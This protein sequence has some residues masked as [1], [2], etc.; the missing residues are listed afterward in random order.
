MAVNA[1]ALHDQDGDTPD[2]VEIN[3][4]SPTPVNLGGWFLTDTA[5][6]LT[7]WRFPS[8]NLPPGGYLVVFASG[9]NRTVAGAELHTNF[10]L[11]AAG[12][13]LALVDPATN[14]ASEF[15]P[16]S[17]PQ[18]AN[19]SFGV[20]QPASAVPLL[21]VGARV[22]VRVPTNGGLGTNWIGREFD[23]GG[24]TMGVNGV[25]YERSPTDPVNYSGLI[26]TDVGSQSYQI[27]GTFYARFPFPLS[28]PAAYSDYRLLLRYDDGFVVWLNGEEVARRNAPDNLAWNS[29]ATGQHVDDQA[30]VAEEFNLAEFE[31]LLVAGTNVLAIQ[32]LN[33]SVTSSDFLILPTVQAVPVTNR[34]VS[35]R[36]FT[37][38]TPGRPNVGGV[39]ELGPIIRNVSHSPPSPLDEQDLLVTAQVTPAFSPISL[40]TLHYRVMFG[41]EVAVPMLDDGAHGDGAAGDRAYGATIPAAASTPGQMVRY[42]I[43]AIDT[44]N[45]PSRIPLLL[46]P[47]GSAEYLGTTVQAPAVTS[48]LPILQWF[49]VDR[50]AAETLTGTRCSLF[51][52]GELYDNIFVRIRGGTALGW[53]KKNYKFEMNED[54]PFLLHPDLP[55][56]NEFNLNATYTDKSYVRSVLTTELSLAAGLPSPEI[57]HLH[58]RQNNQFY[59]VALFVEQVDTDFLRRHGLDENGVLYKVGPGS[60]YDSTGSFEK[61][62][63]RTES[64]ADLQALIDSLGLSRPALDARVFDSFDLPSLVNYVATI[65]VSQNID[66]TD[67]N[68][69]LYRDTLGS[70]E[71]RLFPWDLDL[72][73]GPDYLNTDT[74]V[75]TLCDTAAPHCPSHPFIGTRPYLLHA[76]KWNRLHEAVVK[77]PR[78]REM[79]LRRIRTLTDR[80][81]ATP[82]FQNRIEE[83]YPQLAADVQLDR[84]RWGA[85]AHFPGQTYTL[86]QALD[87]IKKEYL[88]PRLPFLT[89]ATIVGIG[90]NMPRSQPTNVVITITSW[91]NTPVSGNQDEEYVRL[92]NPNGFAVDISGWK[93]DGGIEHTFKPGT[94]I[95]A[96]DAIYLSPNVV[97]F[98]SRAAAPRGGQA[99][100]VQGNYS[101][102]LSAWGETLTLTDDQGRF[103]SS[104]SLVGTPS[105]AQQYLRIT[106]IMYNPVP[107]PGNTNDAQQYEYIELKNTSP[108]LPLDLSG[109]RLTNGVQFSF[110]GSAV[111]SLAPGQIV[112][113]VR[114]QEAFMARYGGAGVP[115]AGIAGQY[116]GA[117]DNAG[118]T[119]RLEDG[120]GEKILEFAYNN[121]WYPITDGLGF[122]LVVRDESAPWDSW[123]EKE[124]WRA[125]GYLNG[126]PGGADPAPRNIAPVRVNEVLAGTD[127]SAMDAIEL[128]NPTV[129]AVDL[130]GWFLTD[131][132]YAPKKYR[133]PGAVTILPNGYLVFDA[134]QLG[135]ESGGFTFSEH[136]NGVYLFSGD[137]NTNLTGYSHG[138]DFAASPGAAAFGRYVT[139]QGEEHFVLQSLATLGATNALPQ[140]G[141]VVIA[142]IMYHPPDLTN[143]A[144]DTLGEF[145]ELQNITATNVPLYRLSGDKPG[146]GSLVRTNTWRLRNAVD[147]D[148]PNDVIL[149]ANSRLLVV[150]FAPTN[151][152]NLA[153][154][155]ARYG[156][157]DG[158]PILGP[159]QGK[160]DNAGET[161]ELEAPDRPYATLTNLTV[162]YVMVDKVAYRDSAPWPTSAD[163]LG[164]SLQRR[165]LDAYGNDPI[166]WIAAGATAGQPNAVKEPPGRVTIRQTGGEIEIAWSS[167]TLEW[168]EDI[169]GPWNVV[170]GASAPSWRFAPEGTRRFFRV[171]G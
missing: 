44:S 48:K 156:V 8:T 67:K 141:P 102:H 134:S 55:R 88:T 111:A 45:K 59:S 63:R 142:E 25:G 117:L 138:F 51:Y 29:V 84:V 58:V 40:V 161:I 170:V 121:R 31:N 152:A 104:S 153:A 13:Y 171:R 34:P 89:G 131:D 60:T 155:R 64:S 16:T 122:D 61:K 43:D 91:D 42:Y 92:T 52:N 135:R 33:A 4:G 19:V 165:V 136:G 109:V 23:D 115:P 149:K 114:N 22:R 127:P 18:V 81:L 82:Y 74:I 73:F 17:R 130:G 140:V 160:L 72:T 90:S 163:G 26:K 2:W 98:R 124:S 106:E 20:V 78:A 30:I 110:A 71:W 27:N 100:F 68:Q 103:V 126:S 150:D 11:D 35:L 75:A 162:P 108:N 3:N 166:N 144:D 28:N 164:D 83:L 101:G 56:K 50:S 38:P 12:E 128:F 86:R 9:K 87:R 113:I 145:I 62:T 137:A 47:S 147:Y 85:S 93:V 118:E 129:D 79:L 1:G 15:A 49:V 119:L 133:I 112:L 151:A 54:H 158:V 69:F 143:G 80:Y 132:F 46:D 57:F 76:G 14:I 125:S 41:G 65:A 36:Y 37:T 66:A 99:L 21:T 7:E 96:N 39:E 24:W 154:F 95:P 159:W 148:F 168:A 53:P 146:T 107:L 94:V 10:K 167:G 169:H 105:L 6:K 120:V 32:G 139:S 77:T 123:G 5:T 97:A 116:T 157:A 70:G